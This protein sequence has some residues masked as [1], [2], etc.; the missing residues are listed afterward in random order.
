[1]WL[2]RDAAGEADRVPPGGRAMLILDVSGGERSSE[3]GMQHVTLV[4]SATTLHHAGQVPSDRS[5]GVVGLG[6]SVV[7]SGREFACPGF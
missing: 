6:A 5:F 2:V 1:V 7:H 3:I 4:S